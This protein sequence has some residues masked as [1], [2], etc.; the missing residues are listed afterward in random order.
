V[1]RRPASSDT[2][3]FVRSVKKHDVGKIYRREGGELVR[4]TVKFNVEKPV[5]RIGAYRRAK[6]DGF[7]E[8]PLRL[9]RN[10]TGERYWAMAR[11]GEYHWWL[12]VKS[13]DGPFR[14]CF[15]PDVPGEPL[16]TQKDAIRT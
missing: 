12:L 8:F 6:G 11:G 15:A 7:V 2:R 4:D 1:R 10:R 13:N 5:L 3:R 9:E 16:G 14:P